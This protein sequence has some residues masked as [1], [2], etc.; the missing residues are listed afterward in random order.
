VGKI[1]FL[2]ELVRESE[3]EVPTELMNTECLT[4]WAADFRLRG[5]GR[6][7]S[8]RCAGSGRDCCRL[9]DIAARRL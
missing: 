1:E 2:V 6:A 9:G 8:R 5:A 7:R 3:T 4:P